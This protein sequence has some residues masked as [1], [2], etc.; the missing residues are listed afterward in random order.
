MIM[1]TYACS[2]SG[3]PFVLTS[4]FSKVHHTWFQVE[5][6]KIKKSSQTNNKHYHPKKKKLTTTVTATKKIKV[7]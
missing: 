6:F 7:K 2:I 5:N 1:T 3:E 4:C